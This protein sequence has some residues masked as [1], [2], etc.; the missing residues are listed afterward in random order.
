MGPL[1][2]RFML[3]F[4]RRLSLRPPA[5]HVHA[6]RV[7][8]AAILGAVALLYVGAAVGISYVAGFEEVWDALQRVDWPWLFAAFGV[9]P[10]AFAG[11]YLGYR[12]IFQ[13][14]AGEALDLDRRGRLVVVAAGFGGILDWGGGAIDRIALRASGATSRDANVRVTMLAGLEQGLL[15]LPCV[16]AA[17]WLVG[18]GARTPSDGFTVPWLVGP[19]AGLVLAVWLTNRV[20]S[21]VD[22][23]G[24]LSVLVDATQRLLTLFGQPRRHALTL[25]GMLLFWGADMF[26]LWA[27]MAAFGFHMNGLAEIV[28]F[29]SAMLVTRRAGPLGGVGLVDLALPPTLWVCGAPFA[30]AV[31]GTFVY[32][33]AMLWLPLPV[34][35]GTLPRLR[36]ILSRSLEAA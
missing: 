23:I 35:L 15:A 12:P 4:G 20:R 34:G 29:G 18:E 32:R 27:G 22:P 6:G 9:V 5:H 25:C 14:A 13:F 16:V 21:R 36:L 7:S 17:A 30:V 31:L 26:A 2:S 24:R 11:Y 33:F 3:L 10:L 28:A 19:A 8:L 1:R